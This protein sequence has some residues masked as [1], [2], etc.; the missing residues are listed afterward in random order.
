MMPGPQ[1]LPH[2]MGDLDELP[3]V[4]DIPFADL[5]FTA[6][7][8][9]VP[10]LAGA[11]IIQNPYRM[12]AAHQGFSDVRSDETGSAGDEKSRQRNPPPSGRMPF[13]RIPRML[14]NSRPAFLPAPIQKPAPQAV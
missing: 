13:Y 7:R 12:P 5:H 4:A 3:A 14:P 10:A 9:Q 11:E 1:P 2:P 6:H 8:G